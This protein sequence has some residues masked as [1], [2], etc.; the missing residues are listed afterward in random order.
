MSGEIILSTNFGNDKL[1]PIKYT[2]YTFDDYKYNKSITYNCFMLSYIQHRYDKGS[3]KFYS[4]Q[5]DVFLNETESRSAFIERS[6]SKY[7]IS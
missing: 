4:N 1:I 2:D 7:P 3:E 5:T 6:M